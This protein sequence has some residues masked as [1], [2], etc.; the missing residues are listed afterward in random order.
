MVLDELIFEASQRQ[1]RADLHRAM[2][3][4]YGS[5]TAEEVAED[6]AWGEFALEQASQAKDWA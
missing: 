5:L 2:E 1:K 4:Y 6:R 3:D